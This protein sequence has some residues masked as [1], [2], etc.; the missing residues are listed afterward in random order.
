[1]MSEPEN[2]SV[3]QST[4]WLWFKGLVEP[5]RDEKGQIRLR[6]GEIVWV[7]PGTAE[8]SDG[9][10]SGPERPTS[11]SGSTQPSGE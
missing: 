6:N 8:R 2:E 3:D 4:A 11:S 5:A 9:R 1:M 7:A 10:L